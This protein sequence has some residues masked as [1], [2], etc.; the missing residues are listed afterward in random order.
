MYL[1]ISV[2][3]F[4]FFTLLRMTEKHSDFLFNIITIA[5]PNKKKIN[6]L[7]YRVS[8]CLTLVMLAVGEEGAFY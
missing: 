8:Y 4:T 2:R 7:K 6:V 3:L 5:V 1:V